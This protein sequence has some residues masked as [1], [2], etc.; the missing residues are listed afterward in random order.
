LLGRACP[1]PVNPLCDKNV[2]KNV[3]TRPYRIIP[4]IS[5]R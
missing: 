3:Q 5:V 4:L 2:N 1:E